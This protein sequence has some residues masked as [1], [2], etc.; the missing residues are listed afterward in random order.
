LGVAK[1]P[2][3]HPEAEQELEEAADWYESQRDGLGREFVAA[4]RVKIDRIVEAPERYPV[5]HGAR[6]A[7]VGRFPYAVVYMASAAGVMIVAIA[8][9]RR[10]PKYWI[11]R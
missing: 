3:F 11:G 8:H 7:L 5:V 4:V 1:A 9:L 10:R 6:R 2:S